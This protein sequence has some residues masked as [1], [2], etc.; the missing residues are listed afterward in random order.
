MKFAVS[1]VVLALVSAVAAQGNIEAIL[2]AMPADLVAVMTYFPASFIQ[3]V[4]GGGSLPTD[5]NQLLAM[6]PGIPTAD[7][8][9]LSSEYV[10]FLSQ[11]ATLLPQPTGTTKAP[12]SSTPSPTTA[13]SSS[14]AATSAPSSH[15]GSASAPASGSSKASHTASD[16]N[17]LGPDE[18]ESGASH[19]GLSAE[20]SGSET[21]SPKT[22]TS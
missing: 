22:K 4:M 3:G 12:A 21:V 11:V 1:S 15:S 2:A 5:V 17:S 7:I 9:K 18:S 19:S 8:P 14:H 16:L 10:A 6:A 13:A 20:S